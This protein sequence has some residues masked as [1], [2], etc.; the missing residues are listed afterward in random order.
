MNTLYWLLSSSSISRLHTKQLSFLVTVFSDR[1]SFVPVFTYTTSQVHSMCTINNQILF[2]EMYC[3]L[4]VNFVTL[5]TQPARY[6]E[7]SQVQENKNK[8]SYHRY[9]YFPSLAAVSNNYTL[10]HIK[11]RFH[12]ISWRVEPLLC[13]DREMGGYMRPISGQRLG[14]HIPVVRQQILNSGTVGIQQ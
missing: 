4:A 3:Y 14:K 2:T 6:C 1:H 13:N 12:W 9:K 7:W 11:S 5:N 8:V 10:L